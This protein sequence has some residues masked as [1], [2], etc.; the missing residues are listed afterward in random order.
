VRALVVIP[1]YE[2][3]GNLRELVEAVRGLPGE[4]PHVLVVDDASPDGTG[5]LADELAAADDG[6]AV[7]HRPRKGGLGPAYRAGLA[8]GLDHGY[9]V[10]I[11]MDAD[12]S[13][14]PAELPRLLA[15]LERADLV[16]GSRYVPGGSVEAWPAHRRWLSRGGNR[17]VRTVTRLPVRDA[18]SGYRVF[19]REVLDAIDLAGSRADGYAF[20]VETALLAWWAGFAV[21][22]A[23]IHFVERREGA[24][25]LSRRVV[26]EAIWRVPRWGLV[27]RRP[28]APH[29]SSVRA[30]GG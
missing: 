8:W 12:L 7:L 22:E 20:Q 17:Y 27:S 2:E 28:R 16:I 3:R 11:Q 5:E 4:A 23:P 18:T 6:I 10:L 15:G 19:R 1:T 30:G 24:S 13:H 25:K 29:P 9:D 14:D 21:G 26:L